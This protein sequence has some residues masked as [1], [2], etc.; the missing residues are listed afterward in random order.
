M[1]CLLV[2]QCGGKEF[3]SFFDEFYENV[4]N[5]FTFMYFLAGD[6]LGGKGHV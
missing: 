1:C 6:A 5:P 4:E 3:L 2:T